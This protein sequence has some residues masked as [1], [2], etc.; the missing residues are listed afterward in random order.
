MTAKKWLGIAVLCTGILLRTWLHHFTIKTLNSSASTENAFNIVHTARCLK[1]EKPAIIMVRM[2]SKT[3]RKTLLNRIL[4]L[5]IHPMLT[6]SK[7]QA[8]IPENTH[9]SQKRDIDSSYT[10]F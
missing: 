1:I 8:N 5:R 10:V 2:I 6:Q 3:L 7:S 9:N 4:N